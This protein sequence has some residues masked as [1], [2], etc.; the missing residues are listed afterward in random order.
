MSQPPIPMP[1]PQGIPAGP[2]VPD[3]AQVNV[4]IARIVEAIHG[5]YQSIIQQL[6]QEN[7]QAQAGLEAQ[8]QELSYLRSLRDAAQVDAAAP[9]DPLG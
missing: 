8:G 4:P 7:A 5:Q 3:N 1:A 9:A 6:I 2:P